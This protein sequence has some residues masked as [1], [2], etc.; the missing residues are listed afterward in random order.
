MA[1]ML[2]LLDRFQR[3]E[4]RAFRA[5]MF[6]ALGLCAVVPICHMWLLHYEAPQAKLAVAYDVLMGVTYL[7][8]SR[9]S[10]PSGSGLGFIWSG[11]GP[12]YEAPQAGG[13]VRCADGGHAP[14]C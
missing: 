14:M 11:Q 13:G 3:N 5:G 2:A 9:P 6:A 12:H 4:W 1:V 8:S 10:R 7:V